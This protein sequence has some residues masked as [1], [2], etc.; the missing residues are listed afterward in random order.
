MKIEI[1][2][3]HIGNLFCFFF[4]YTSSVS[5]SLSKTRT[6]N[7]LLS[8]TIVPIF[9]ESLELLLRY[10]LILL[11]NFTQWKSGKSRKLAFF[12][13]SELYPELSYPDAQYQ[14]ISHHWMFLLLAPFVA[15]S[16]LFHMFVI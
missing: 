13:K 4:K 2:H 3:V 11:F 9:F 5:A 15:T 8:T 1:R 12:I 10:T 14:L 6:T 7:L 16:C